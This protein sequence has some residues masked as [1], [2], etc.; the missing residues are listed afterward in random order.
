MAR[1]Q[2]EKEG[3]RTAVVCENEAVSVLVLGLVVAV[4]QHLRIGFLLVWCGVV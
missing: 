2:S 1:A 3:H 4:V